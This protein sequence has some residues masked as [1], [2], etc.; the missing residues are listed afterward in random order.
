MYKY[1]KLSP[2]NKIFRNKKIFIVYEE[3]IYFWLF[4]KFYGILL[5]IIKEVLN[6]KKHIRFHTNY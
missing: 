2:L 5:N 6:V 4:M 3:E 1:I